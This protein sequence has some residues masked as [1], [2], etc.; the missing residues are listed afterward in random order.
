VPVL[1][2]LA[3]IPRHNVV[4]CIGIGNVHWNWSCALELVMCIGIGHQI[5]AAPIV[6][7]MPIGRIPLAIMW[8]DMR[9][10]NRHNVVV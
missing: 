8:F 3:L 4:M 10:P 9:I 2:N 6:R 5:A 7:V 1:G